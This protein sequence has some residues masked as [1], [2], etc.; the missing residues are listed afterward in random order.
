MKTPVLDKRDKQQIIALLSRRI[1]EYTPEWNYAE[2]DSDPGA[3][4]VELFSEMF[5]QTIE[6]FNQLPRKYYT[7]FLNILGVTPAGVT[8][9][10]GFVR[11]EIG[12]TPDVP[13]AVPAGTEVFAKSDDGNIIYTTKRRID[14]TGAQIEDI[15]YVDTAGGRIELLGAD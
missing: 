14:I 13:V 3:A 2:G 8:P 9:A 4:I 15:Y 5:Y 6:R 7:E 1:K 12:G 11:F 10:A